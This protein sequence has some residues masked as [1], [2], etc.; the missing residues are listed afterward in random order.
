MQGHQLTFS[1]PLATMQ[2]RSVIKVAKP[3]HLGGR[4]RV[5]WHS[6]VAL[7][8]TGAV[9]SGISSRLAQKMNL[10]PRE[11]TVLSTAAGTVNSSKD[12]VLLDLL[13]DNAVIPVKVAI[14]DSIPGVDNDFLIGMD[15]IQCGDMVISTD[16][17]T[18]N[19][20]VSF[21]PY[22]GLFR[23]AGAFFPAV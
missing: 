15:V 19:F 20:H 10:V 22:P 21:K 1:S 16:H 17:S 9:T 13:I 2:I 6:A 5:P 3:R 23:P 4:L 12:I 11:Q 8:D 14:V 7:W 18:H